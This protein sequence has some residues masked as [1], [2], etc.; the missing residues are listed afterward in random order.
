MPAEKNNRVELRAAE[1]CFP[2]PTPVLTSAG[3]G[4]T[5]IELMQHTGYVD[6]IAAPSVSYHLTLVYLSRSPHDVMQRMDGRVYEERFHRGEIAI[7]PAGLLCEWSWKRRADDVLEIRLGDAFLREV[8]ESVEVD[9]GGIEIVHRLCAPY[10]QIE[11]IGLSLKAEVEADGI[12][13]GRLY[14]E[15]LANALAICLIR[16]HSSVGRKAASFLAGEHT[17]GLS[18]SARSKK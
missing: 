1:E 7:V 16:D 5:G 18:P 2:G 15:S 11:R 6:E 13:G 17:G 8:A 10:P 14:A 3:R 4:W 9:P 12:L